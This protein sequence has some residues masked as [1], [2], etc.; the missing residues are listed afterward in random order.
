VR[1]TY[2]TLRT[3]SLDDKLQARTGVSGKVVDDYLKFIACKAAAGDYYAS[4]LSPPAEVDAVWH[5][6]LLDTLSYHEMCESVV[7]ARFLHHNPDGALD[8]SGRAERR[9]RCLALYAKVFGEPPAYWKA[10]CASRKRQAT[11]PPATSSSTA[12]SHPR[13]GQR[14]SPSARR[15]G[16][17]I[18]AK[19][20][21][22]KTLTLAVEP[23][24]SIDA[25]KEMIQEQEG[26]PP[27]QLG[28]VFAGKSLGGPKLCPHSLASTLSEQGVVELR[29]T[30][31]DKGLDVAGNKAALVKRL[32][33]ALVEEHRQQYAH[34]T[35]AHYNIQ[36]DSTVHMV[37]NLRGC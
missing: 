20:L 35:L 10:M 28:L 11:S 23:S 36:K 16:M 32:V 9:K 31:Q 33:V 24:D 19:T 12:A 6:H 3:L 8:E 1:E 14:S 37:L 4:L 26:I 7:P 2:A 30:L 21:T 13:L 22:G 5:A 34:L 15:P 27:E 29:A 17:Q 25:I 18:F